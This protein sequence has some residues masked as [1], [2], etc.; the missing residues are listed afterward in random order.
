MGSDNPL[1]GHSIL[2]V[3]DDPLIR[4]ELIS[5]YQSVG[6]QVIAA[7]THEEGIRATEEYPIRAALLD[8][9][10]DEDNVARLCKRFS[11][12]QIPY[13]F[14]TGYSGIEKIFPFAVILEKPAS[15]NVLLRSM[16]DLIVSAPRPLRRRLP[17]RRK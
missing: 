8:Y 14:Y 4:M 16:T 15:G 10:L 3:E 2:I 5:L 17:V 7:S 9:G 6:A 11:E 13:M 1:Q 12:Y